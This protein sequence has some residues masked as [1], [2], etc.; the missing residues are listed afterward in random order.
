MA[1]GT[2][3]RAIV[4]LLDR[5]LRAAEESERMGSV[6]EILVLA[7][8]ALEAQNDVPSALVALER[9]LAL[10]EPEGFVRRFVDEGPPMARL[11][12]EALSQGIFPDYTGRLLSAFPPVESSPPTIGQQLPTQAGLLEPLSERELEVLALVA[13]GLSNPEIAGKLYISP[14][15]VKVHTR[16]IF[17]KLDVHNRTQAVARGRSLG[18]LPGE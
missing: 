15:T 16:N 13:L 4:G 12:Y 7:A 8:L 18:L 10:A 17:G 11:L 9:A 5:L 14:N 1:G 6:I 2:A 3:I